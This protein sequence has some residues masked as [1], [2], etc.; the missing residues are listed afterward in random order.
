MRKFTPGSWKWNG[1]DLWHVGKGYMPEEKDDP[2]LYAGISVDPELIQHE[3]VKANVRLIESAPDMYCALWVALS[4]L[5]GLVQKE[6][7]HPDQ[8]GYLCEGYA[9]YQQVKEA[10]EKAEGR[11]RP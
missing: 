7:L 4:V 5:S 1:C 9:A 2:H 3:H 8:K 10:L 11:E 6:G